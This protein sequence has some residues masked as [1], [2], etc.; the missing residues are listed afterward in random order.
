MRRW[1]LSAL[2]AVPSL[3]AAQNPPRGPG[4]PGGPNDSLRNL[5]VFPATMT[6]QQLIPIMQGMAGALGVECEYCHVVDSANPGPGGR[7]RLN[8]PADDKRTKQT[9]RIMLRMVMDINRRLD[10][11]PER[12]QPNVTVSCT[13]CHRGVARPA[14]LGQVILGA[15]Q[16]GGMDSARNAYRGLHDRYYGRASYDFGERSLIGTAVE[17]VRQNRP[18]DAMT[19]LAINAEQFPQSA[20]THDTMGDVVLSKG[21]TAGAVAHYREALQR[22]STDRLARFR[23]RALTGSAGQFR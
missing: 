23:L 9:A 19:L 2:L 6:R 1:I 11:I 15:Y 14:P 20:A 8:F 10:S 17:L 18:D 5:K 4:G 16:A 21:D 13:T 22:D 7:P 12:P 3:L